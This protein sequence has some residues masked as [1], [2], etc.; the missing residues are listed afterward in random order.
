VRLGRIAHRLEQA[1]RRARNGGDGGSWMVDLALATDEEL[2]ML[3]VALAAAGGTV[4]RANSG[5]LA[6][7]VVA[8]LDDLERRT[9]EAR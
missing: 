3:R 9:K 7:A 2:A 5:R 4:T 8:L 1:E 6:P